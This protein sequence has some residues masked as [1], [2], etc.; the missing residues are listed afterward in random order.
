[1]LCSATA[2][3]QRDQDYHS[4]ARHHFR[5]WRAEAGGDNLWHSFTLPRMPYHLAVL[6]AT[7]CQVLAQT[8]FAHAPFDTSA[9]VIVHEDSAEVM[10]TVGSA[11]GENYLRISQVNPAR[12]AKRHPFPLNAGM[13]TNVF[14]AAAGEKMLAPREADVVTDG[15]EFQFHFEY[16][17]APAKS[18]RLET[19]FTP[20]SS[21]RAPRHWW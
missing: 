9:R 11:L 15:L 14:A 2:R 5:G 8:T 10:V 13:A 1:M 21:R 3:P 7:V 18:L 12:L 17:L 6:I 19:F 16:M 20:R 4:A